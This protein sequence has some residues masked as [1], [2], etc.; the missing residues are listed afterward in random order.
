MQSE[1]LIWINGESATMIAA[2]D[3]AVAYGDGFFTTIALSAGRPQ[4]WTFHLDRIAESSSRLLIDDLDIAQLEKEVMRVAS[5]KRE[6]TLKVI[7]SR[8]C[9]V[10]GY[11]V[12]GAHH[13]VR[14]LIWTPPS[15]FYQAMQQAGVDLIACQ[16]PVAEIPSL[17]GLKTLNRLQQVM[18]KNELEKKGAF[19]GVVCDL[20]GLM[21]ECC[22][23]NLFW[24]NR[25]RLYTP[26]LLTGGVTGVMRR[27]VMD[28][29]EA[30]CP[31][32]RSVEEVR[33][34]PDALFAADEVF[35]T[36]SLMPVLP[37]SSFA[38]HQY[39]DFTFARYLQNRVA[40]I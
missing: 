36:N 28:Q 9:G 6:G 16:M 20:D 8:G 25:D 23:A 38:G 1:P 17:V 40:Q 11:S 21:V 30:G 14:I 24:R 5:E 13:P 7:V 19:E 29:V 39:S 10:R 35:I 4:L 15:G 32:I 27:F 18:I 37:V 31:I 34:R 26:A 12:K 3:R 33:A 22:S 2:V